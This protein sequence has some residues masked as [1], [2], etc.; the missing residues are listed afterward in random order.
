MPCG[1]GRK[2]DSISGNFFA[3]ESLS[4]VS[5]VNRLIFLPAGNQKICKCIFTGIIYIHTPTYTI[6]YIHSRVL[7]VLYGYVGETG[8]CRNENL[9]RYLERKKPMANINPN[10][11]ANSYRK[12]GKL[13]HPR[14]IHTYMQI[15]AQ[16]EDSTPLGKK[17]KILKR[18][19]KH[20]LI[21]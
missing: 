11:V 18:K 5:F 1:N 19:K 21:K 20:Q 12:T 7:N 10:K 9:K 4:A 8:P 16:Q 13:I 6:Q 3:R 14:Y 15:H 17:T 2:K